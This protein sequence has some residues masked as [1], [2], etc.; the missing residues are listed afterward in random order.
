[1]T[2]PGHA[3]IRRY[4]GYGVRECK[5]GGQVPGAD[6][7]SR[8]SAGH[9]LALTNVGSLPQA[10]PSWRH[11]CPGAAWPHRARGVVPQVAEWMPPAPAACPV[12][13]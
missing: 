6:T 11:L 13:L 8:E 3:R 1:M 4:H 2:M 9:P 5:Y 7:A 12:G 10:L